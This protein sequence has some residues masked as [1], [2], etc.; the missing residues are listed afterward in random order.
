MTTTDERHREQA[1]RIVKLEVTAF[2]CALANAERG[3]TVHLA[4]ARK[5]LRA[6]IEWELAAEYKAGRAEAE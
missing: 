5:T 6:A 3:D 1:E 2:I 4:E